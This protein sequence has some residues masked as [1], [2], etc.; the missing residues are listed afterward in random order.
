VLEQAW[1]EGYVV[2]VSYT[3]GFYAELAPSALGFAGLLGGVQAPDPQHPFTYYELGCGQGETSALLAAAHPQGRFFGVDFNPTHI[4]NAARLA[5]DGGVDN[6][7][8]LEKSFAELDAM[9]LP[10]A[11]YVALHGV[12]SW[13]SDEHRRQIVS[14]LRRRLKP[15]GVVYVSYNCLP[16]LAQVMPLQRLLAGHAQDGAGERMERVRRAL[17]FAGRLEAAGATYF[18]VNPVAKVRLAQLGKQDP[19]YLAHEYFNS[20]WTPCYH[21]DVAKDLAEAKLGYAASATV[22]DNFDQFVLKPEWARLVGEQRD[23]TGAET[24]KDYARNQVFRKDVFTRGAPRAAPQALDAMLDAT[25]F[26]LARPRG[27]CSLSLKTQAGE[28]TLHEDIHAPVLDALARQPMTFAELRAAPECA[29]LDRVR[30]RQAVFALAAADNVAAALPAAGEAGRRARTRTYNDAL[31]ARAAASVS[32][33]TVLASPV[34]GSGV[35][36]SA[37]HRLFLLS[38]TEE[39][40]VQRARVELDAGRLRLKENARPVET[41]AAGFF[42][43]ARSFYRALGIVD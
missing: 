33:F 13:I 3:H 41:L 40:A 12:W 28:V 25:R 34:L 9:E 18:G 37:L 31:L 8:F 5:Q 42:G 21:A 35:P 32:E 4:H 17:E 10:E 23:R 30:A 15:G 26:A 14:F 11:D 24:I 7:R 19:R 22:V 16:G 2:D 6:V 1:A 36:V 38:K 29:G 39:E 27:V 43:G 20:N